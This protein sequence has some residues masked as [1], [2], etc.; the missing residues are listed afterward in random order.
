M[1][2]HI[3]IIRTSVGGLLAAGELK[4]KELGISGASSQ[5]LL[6]ICISLNCD[7]YVTGHGAINYLDQKLFETSQTNVE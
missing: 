6:D 3:A 7:T 1:K 4:S 2:K 5:R